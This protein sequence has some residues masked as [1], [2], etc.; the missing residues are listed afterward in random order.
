MLKSIF[1]PIVILCHFVTES[2][3]ISEFGRVNIESLIRT[4][5]MTTTTTTATLT[6]TTNSTSNSTNTST[7]QM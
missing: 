2:F 3:A 7:A 5:A 6:I 4:L 1:I